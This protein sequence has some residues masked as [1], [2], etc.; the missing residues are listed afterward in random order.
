MTV[1]RDGSGRIVCV[2]NVPEAI[3]I[4]WWWSLRCG[5]RSGRCIDRHIRLLEDWRVCVFED[6]VVDDDVLPFL[7]VDDGG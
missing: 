6:L 5:D 7:V 4:E 2:G 1:G 3:E